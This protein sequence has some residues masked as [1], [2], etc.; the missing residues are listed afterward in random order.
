M[1]PLGALPEGTCA[2]AGCAHNPTGIDPTKEQWQ[3]IADLCKEKGHI[4]FFD[5][6]YQGFASGSLDQVCLNA[7]DIYRM[8]AVKLTHC[9]CCR[10]SACAAPFVHSRGLFYDRGRTC[11]VLRLRSPRQLPLTVQL[12]SS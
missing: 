12:V 9:C 11:V 2:L 10:T 1:H 7:P 6:A 3:A 8:F 5:V 4:P